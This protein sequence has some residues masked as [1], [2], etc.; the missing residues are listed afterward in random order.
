MLPGQRWV[1]L[2][3][4]GPLGLRLIAPADGAT[5]PLHTW[6]GGRS[7]RIHH[8]ELAVEDPAGVLGVRPAGSPLSLMGRHG[9]PVDLWELAPEDNSGLG[10]VL[11]P[12]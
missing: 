1:D 9:T 6:L 4:A 5:G 3:W 7:G 10:L 11:A 8:L 12:A 2:Q